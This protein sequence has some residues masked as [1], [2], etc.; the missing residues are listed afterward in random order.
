MMPFINRGMP[1]SLKFCQRDDRQKSLAS[2]DDI[3]HKDEEE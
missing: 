1:Q 3:G 2:G